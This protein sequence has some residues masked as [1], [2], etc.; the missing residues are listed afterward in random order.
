MLLFIA[1]WLDSPK[2]SPNTSRHSQSSSF[3]VMPQTSRILVN[4]HEQTWAQVAGQSPPQIISEASESGNTGLE[5]SEVRD[6]DEL[7]ISALSG[8]VEG[9]ATYKAVKG[10]RE[11]RERL[12]LDNQNLFEIKYLL[13]NH[14][15]YGT[16]ARKYLYWQT[17]SSNR[18]HKCLVFLT[19]ITRSGRSTHKSRHWFLDA[20]SYKLKQNGEFVTWTQAIA[21]TPGGRNYIEGVKADSNLSGEELE[22]LKEKMHHLITCHPKL[23]AFFCKQ[24]H[25]DLVFTSEWKRRE[26][27][28]RI[29][30]ILYDSESCSHP[31]C[32]LLKILQ[33]KFSDARRNEDHYF[34]IKSETSRSLCRTQ[35]YQAALPEKSS[36]EPDSKHFSDDN[37]AYT[38]ISTHISH[39]LPARSR[40]PA[41]HYSCARHTTSSSP[42]KRPD[43][44]DTLITQLAVTS[45]G[46]DQEVVKPALQDTWSRPHKHHYLSL[47]A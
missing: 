32:G 23:M 37:T 13:T 30:N 21:A 15:I 17:A 25:N 8:L 10:Q 38:L 12:Y 44:L 31:K 41:F 7:F 34:P 39:L 11:K 24:H 5:D 6:V 22:R 28:W 26:T 27:Y 33:G 40:H 4:G 1:L 16:G 47:G 35:K 14:S 20:I 9:T 3:D 18:G 46:V 42:Y 2:K 19:F 29:D 36:L 43:R 45:S